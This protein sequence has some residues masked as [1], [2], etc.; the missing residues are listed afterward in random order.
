MLG[1]GCKDTWKGQDNVCFQVQASRTLTRTAETVSYCNETLAPTVTERGVRLV[2]Q[3]LYILNLNSQ[4]NFSRCLV[5]GKM[6]TSSYSILPSFTG[7]SIVNATLTC[8][9]RERSKWNVQSCNGSECGYLSIAP[10]GSHF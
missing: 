10:R 4:S 7:L 6:N 3:F 9:V 8:A 1:P 5:I 2:E